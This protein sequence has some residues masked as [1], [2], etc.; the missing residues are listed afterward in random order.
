MMLTGLSSDF[1]L[2]LMPFL[3]NRDCCQ[4]VLQYRKCVHLLCDKIIE[5]EGINNE[6]YDPSEMSQINLCL[7]F[8]FL[9]DCRIITCYAIR[10]L[11]T[12]A[13]TQKWYVQILCTSS[14]ERLR[15][16]ALRTGFG[17]QRVLGQLVSYPKIRNVNFFFG[18]EGGWGM[19]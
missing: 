16:K 14:Q 19:G 7:H 11:R 12:I 2:L 17:P 8:N 13:H 4:C 3:R 6:E 5:Q 1:A 15:R 9:V 10:I 18:V